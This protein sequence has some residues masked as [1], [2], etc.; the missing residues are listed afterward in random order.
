MRFKWDSTKE[1][2][3]VKKHGI[4]FEEAQ[5]A[6]TCGTVV[7]LKEDQRHDEQ[8]FVFLGI[9]RRLIVLVVVVAYP[10]ETLTR[11]ISARKATKSERILY[12]T[13]L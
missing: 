3:N 4:S 11:I 12:E 1:Q 13:Q 5:E 10:E 6:L 8:R 2:N 7:V 9:C